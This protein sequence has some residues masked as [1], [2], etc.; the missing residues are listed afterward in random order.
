[1]ANLLIIEDDLDLCEILNSYLTLK[2][3]HLT[4]SN[5][6]LE[7][8]ERSK[9]NF[10]D[11][12]LLDIFLPDRD[13]FFVCKSIRS[14]SL[15]PILFISGNDDRSNII[16]AL[17]SGG[18]DY[19][20]KPF[21][22]DELDARIEANM[23]RVDISNSKSSS[24]KGKL[25]KFKTFTLDLESQTIIKNEKEILPLSPLE[26]SILT[27][28][29]KNPYIILS[30]ED[31]YSNVWEEDSLGD[32]RTVM[33]HVSNLRKKIKHPTQPYIL[34]LRKKGYIFSPE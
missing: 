21:D 34:T 33:V 30:Y 22:F 18:D 24:D 14:H 15:S 9:N 7:A 11:V 8:I 10:F 25:L 13:G 4:I 28:M 27:Y 31:I 3:H 20:I 32:F 6:G 1:M 23:R 2:G 12:I 29:I 16:K 26:F 19:I 5:T 17:N